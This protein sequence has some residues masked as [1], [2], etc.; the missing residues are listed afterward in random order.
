M[1][2]LVDKVTSGRVDKVNLQVRSIMSLLHID[3]LSGFSDRFPIDA[4]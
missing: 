3:H 4:R 1:A 2:F